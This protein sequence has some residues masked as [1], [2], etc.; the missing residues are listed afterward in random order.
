MF[1]KLIFLG[2]GGLLVLGLLFGRNLMPYA[3]TAVQKAQGW[4][5]SM[6]DTN[7]K[8]DT[9]RQSLEKLE[10]NI[11]PMV[12]KMAQQK[13]EIE[14]LSDEIEESDD[15]LARSHGHIIKLRNHLDSGDTSYV[16]TRGKTFSQSQVRLNLERSFRN[17]KMQEERVAALRKT[18]ETREQG[19]EAAQKNLELTHVKRVELANKIDSLEAQLRMLEVSRT[20]SSFNKFDSSE[21]SRIEDMVDE[22]QSRI[23]TEVMVNR[24]GPELGGEIPVDELDAGSGDIIDAVDAYFGSETDSGIVSK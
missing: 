1:K 21:L 20:A 4:A 15:S 17:Y 9:V 3:G 5:D 18:M 11:E 14:R 10:E 16:S 19:L 24:M 22:V 12:Y 7:Y 8:I 2:A 13:V 23:D 6:V